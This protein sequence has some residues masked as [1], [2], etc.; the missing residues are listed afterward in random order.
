MS[1][2]HKHGDGEHTHN[3]L[4]PD[5]LGK[6]GIK[7]II[8]GDLK[9]LPNIS[10]KE[11]KPKKKRDNTKKKDDL[12][13]LVKTIESKINEFEGKK[14]IVERVLSSGGNTIQQ[15]PVYI[16]QFSVPEKPSRDDLNDII[17][18]V[19]DAENNLR[20]YYEQTT[21]QP[22]TEIEAI[23][24]NEQG[25]NINPDDDLPELEENI[26][27]N[28][29][30]LIESEPLI[31]TVSEIVS[32]PENNIMNWFR[33]NTPR[34]LELN[35]AET[36]FQ[37]YDR[38][39]DD[40]KLFLENM[41]KEQNELIELK[42]I[43]LEE[44]ENIL[45]QMTDVVKLSEKDYLLLED[46]YASKIQIIEILEDGKDR[47][48][49]IK[50]QEILKL[51]LDASKN[52][53]EL[54]DTIDILKKDIDNTSTQLETYKKMNPPKL[55]LQSRIDES[56]D[57]NQFV[58][59][60]D[61][62]VKLEIQREKDALAMRLSANFQRL[63]ITHNIGGYNNTVR[64]EE[65]RERIG[66]ELFI[67]A[68]QKIYG[69]Y[70]DNIQVKEFINRM[71][72][73][74][75]RADENQFIYARPIPPNEFENLEPEIEE[76]IDENLEIQRQLDEDKLELN[77][78][79]TILELETEEY[80]N[81]LNQLEQ[82]KQEYELLVDSLETAVEEAGIDDIDQISVVEDER[83]RINL[84]YLWNY[85]LE[86]QR[87]LDETIKDNSLR[88][89]SDKENIDKLKLEY[90]Q[91]RD[92]YDNEKNKVTKTKKIKPKKRRNVQ[93]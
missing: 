16:P 8:K 73:L 21:N 75:D 56:I 65:L 68:T 39:E 4:L 53:D 47:D 84:L 27:E 72:E 2:R 19:F 90:L 26:E 85:I 71:M 10:F 82:L 61:E 60:S 25:Q 52:Q 40:N 45:K 69:E 59:T 91:K 67:Y 51:K 18:E 46:E 31:D 15:V 92:I 9:N 1:G 89:L 88:L 42:K 38:T 80:E 20:E 7:L 5:K 63:G 43:E 58:L 3:E 48:D 64:L 24:E 70:T 86:Q 66:D 28:V 79:E 12:E 13:K 93:E 11:K 30:D 50:E 57:M 23:F 62:E 22:Y 14:Q 55:S 81:N 77:K 37:A 76:V 32:I 54:Q 35:Q 17:N 83:E 49:K 33:D 41:N 6:E 44:K 87:D 29:P 34:P 78:L 74:T 36:E